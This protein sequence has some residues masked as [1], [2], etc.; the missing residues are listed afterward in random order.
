MAKSGASK[1]FVPITLDNR[2]FVEFLAEEPEGVLRLDPGPVRVSFR[3]AFEHRN[4][5][6]PMDAL[7][8]Q[9]RL[10][11]AAGRLWE[12]ESVF[13]TRLFIERLI[14]VGR[15][16]GP[17]WFHHAPAEW[18]E[19]FE[20]RAMISGAGEL[21]DDRFYRYFYADNTAF[22]FQFKYQVPSFDVAHLAGTTLLVRARPAWGWWNPLPVEAADGSP[23]PADTF[24]VPEPGEEEDEWEDEG[25]KDKVFADFEEIDALVCELDCRDLLFNNSAYDQNDGWWGEGGLVCPPS[26]RRLRNKG[27][28]QAGVTFHPAR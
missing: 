25:E 2:W 5:D 15:T 4:T 23:L 12:S 19:A 6:G 18:R 28:A 21:H 20:K 7:A 11:D 24:R 10:A 14:D 1:A 3:L 8:S 27:E 9:V 16:R 26:F 17:C 13:T 22:C